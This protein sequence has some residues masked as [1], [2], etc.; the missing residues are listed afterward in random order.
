MTGCLYAFEERIA[1]PNIIWLVGKF[2][3]AGTME[4][5]QLYKSELGTPQGGVISPLLANIYLHYVLDLW[6]EKRFKLKSKGYVELIRYCDDFIMV[7]ESE[8][9]AMRFI[10][11]LEQRLAKFNLKVSKEKTR[12]LKFGRR[13]WKRLQLTGTKAETFDF[14]GFTHYCS[15][16]RNGYFVMMHKTSGIRL[17]RK[18]TEINTWLRE[19]RNMVPLKELWAMIKAKFIGHY[20]YFGINGNIHSLKKFYWSVKSMIFKWINRRGQKKSMDLKQFRNYL[21]WNPLPQ[22][23][24]YHAILY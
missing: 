14:L 4:Q 24:V 20:N 19:T 10:P 18:L 16:S 1:D 22:P 7:A 13:L 8:Y 11:E 2:L 12:V 5:S 6:F 9:D 15:K 21:Q 23:R 3:R 17:R